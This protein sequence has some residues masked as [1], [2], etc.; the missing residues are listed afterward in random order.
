MPVHRLRVY[1]DNSAFGGVHD[2]EFA[3]DSKRFF[4]PVRRGDYRVLVSQIVFE[5]IADAPD[6]VRQA[7]QDL[8]DE[9]LETVPVQEEVRR[10]ADAYV[11]AK[12]LSRKWAFD[13][14]QVAAAT[15]ANADLILSWNFAHIANYDRIQRF[16][17]VNLMNGYR[18]VD[19]RSPQELAY[20]DKDEDV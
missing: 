9:V 6:K 1:V 3:E 10:L 17:A 7:L 19:I 18:T 11:S 16:N 5:E 13:A 20:G 12:A 2:E 8:P 4:E 14:L 15:V